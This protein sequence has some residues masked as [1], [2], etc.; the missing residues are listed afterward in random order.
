MFF[1]RSPSQ[2]SPGLTREMDSVRTC[3]SAAALNMTLR[4]NLWHFPTG[5]LNDIE[6]QTHA[7]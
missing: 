2:T 1:L 5:A 3:V 7:F 6:E 4:E